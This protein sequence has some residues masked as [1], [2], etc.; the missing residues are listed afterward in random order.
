VIGRWK[1]TTCVAASSRPLLALLL[2]GRCCP[3]HAGSDRRSWEWLRRSSC[4][5]SRVSSSAAEGQSVPSF[6]NLRR[7]I[8][9]ALAQIGLT[10]TFLAFHAFD[11]A[12]A[13]AVTL[14]RLVVTKRK[15]LEWETAAATAA[16]AAGVVGQGLHRFVVEMAASPIIAAAVTLT[17][18]AREPA[19]LPQRR[20]FLLWAIAPVMAYRLSMVGARGRLP[21]DRDRTVCGE[22]RARRGAT[23]ET[24]VT[25][26]DAW[27]APATTRK[28]VT[29]RSWARRTSPTNIGM[30]M[31]STLA[32]HDLGCLD[33]RVL[34]RLNATVTT[35]ESL[36]RYQGHF[37]NWYDTASRAAAPRSFRPS[38]AATLIA[39]G[40]GLIQLEEKLRRL[41]RLA[42]WPTGRPARGNILPGDA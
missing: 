9:T 32:A 12:H 25:E 28:P 5:C 2:D 41:A 31:L 24:F 42:G 37:L 38:T 20:C 6:G 10:V 23:F 22:P 15:M 1:M 4:R 29:L 14:V 21:S 7:D 19:A 35:L 36:E 3:A 11:T 30:S 33:R 26:A 8:A 13:I 39:L 17:L 16:K 27:L 18:A 34:R 40:Q